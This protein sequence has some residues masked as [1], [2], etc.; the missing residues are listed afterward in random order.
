MKNSLQECR[1]INLQFAGKI[2][3]IMDDE[4]QKMTG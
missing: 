1:N 2:R 3:K 4:I